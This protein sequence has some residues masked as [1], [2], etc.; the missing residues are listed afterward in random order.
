MDEATITSDKNGSYK[1]NGE[2]YPAP[3]KCPQPWPFASPYFC[4]D[5]LYRNPLCRTL[6]NCDS[7]KLFWT[8]AADNGAYGSPGE[9][10][11]DDTFDAASDKDANGLAVRSC[12]QTSTWVYETST[13][14]DS[15]GEVQNTASGPMQVVDKDNSLYDNFIE[16]AAQENRRTLDGVNLTPDTMVK[17]R[18]VMSLLDIYRDYTFT[19]GISE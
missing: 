17:A 19:I 6:S 9:P 3:D 16:C 7:I 10:F 12:T 5:G 1:P 11:Y 15:F 18:V 8:L 4:I 14:G 2:P 13:D